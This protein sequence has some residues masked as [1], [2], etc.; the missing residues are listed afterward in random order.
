MKEKCLG[1]YLVKK[2]VGSYDLTRAFL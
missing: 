1:I 2:G